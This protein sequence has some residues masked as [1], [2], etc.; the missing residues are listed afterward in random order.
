M[1]VAPNGP[2]TSLGGRGVLLRWW[3]VLKEGL[4]GLAVPN[5]PGTTASGDGWFLC[6]GWCPRIASGGQ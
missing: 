4:R 1:A 3:S 5:G 6:G 2:D